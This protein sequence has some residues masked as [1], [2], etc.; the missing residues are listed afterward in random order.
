MSNSESLPSSWKPSDAASSPRSQNTERRFLRR[1]CF[2]FKML[3]ASSF[4]FLAADGATMDVKS[5]A[6]DDAPSV[7]LNVGNE[8]T[9]GAKVPNRIRYAVFYT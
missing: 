3:L 7:G 1:A 9:L 6:I 4:Y 5:P 8:F 2:S